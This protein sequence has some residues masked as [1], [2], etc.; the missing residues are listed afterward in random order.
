M[1]RIL[2]S[3]AVVL[4]LAFAGCAFLKSEEPVLVADARA[5]GACVLKQALAGGSN[6]AEDI[7]L[8]CGGLAGA[9]VMAIL[10]DYEAGKSVRLRGD[11]GVP[12]G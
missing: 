6:V 9:E 3:L 7:G 5:Q 8:A 10:K 4:G 11:A 2:P 12:K 1:I